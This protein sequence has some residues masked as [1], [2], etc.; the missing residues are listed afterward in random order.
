[1]TAKNSIEHI[2]PQNPKEENKDLIYLPESE[3][4]NLEKEE[5]ENFSPINDFGNL[6]L[7]TSGINSSYSNKSFGEKKQQFMNNRRKLDSLKSSIIF[8]NDSWNWSYAQAH[9][10]KMITIFNDYIDNLNYN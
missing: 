9:R 6:V 5:K 10:D 2:F 4:L 8:N 1:M 3:K 7:L